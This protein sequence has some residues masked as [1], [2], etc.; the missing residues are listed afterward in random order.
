MITTYPLSL[1]G[2][3]LA[4]PPR[5]PNPSLALLSFL[6]AQ[7]ECKA[8]TEALEQRLKVLEDHLEVPRFCLCRWDKELADFSKAFQDLK[9]ALPA[10]GRWS[11]AFSEAEIIHNQDAPFP[12]LDAGRRGIVHS[13]QEEVSKA[14]NLYEQFWDRIARLAEVQAERRKGKQYSYSLDDICRL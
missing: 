4:Y 11:R 1:D 8:K 2:V 5:G 13:I 6:K 3:A 9:I 7:Q 12:A 10:A 14:L